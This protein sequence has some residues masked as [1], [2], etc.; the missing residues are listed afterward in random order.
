MLAAGS[1]FGHGVPTGIEDGSLRER[2]N[3]MVT[4]KNKDGSER[5][6]ESHRL[7]SIL[8]V[9]LL[10]AAWLLTGLTADA[11]A[12]DVLRWKFKPGETLRF[13][14]EQKTIMSMKARDTERKESQTHTLDFSWKVLGVGPGGEAEITHRIERVRMRLEAPPLMPFDFDSASSKPVQPGFEAVARQLKTQVSAE[15]TFKMKPNGEIL[16]I[17]VSEETLKRLRES[18]PA[19]AQGAEI[20]EKAL[21][22]TL[23]QAGPPAFP[24]GPLE[25]GKSWT[26]KAARV[27]L[28]VGTLV[29]DRTFTYQGPDPKSP[30][31]Q[32]VD[33]QTTV[34]I[35]PIEGS[36]VKAAIRKQEGKGSITIDGDAGRVV[37]TRMGLK[38]DIGLSGMGQSVEQS[39][40]TNSTMTLMP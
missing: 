19:E 21:K 8:P 5:I 35:E 2:S 33:L 6:H 18:V 10:A 15:F 17:K 4:N 27:Q 28:P 37:S 34:R 40:E 30:T 3:G 26:P 29:L 9:T 23:L 12:A 14:V 36:D 25:P 13:S 39:T 32:L 38:L 20:S 16:D 24:E 7:L 11:T 1:S 22:E 31:L